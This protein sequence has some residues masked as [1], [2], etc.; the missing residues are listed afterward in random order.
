MID[1]TQVKDVK[2]LVE[3]R[4]ALNFFINKKIVAEIYAEEGNEKIDLE[5]DRRMARKLLENV[6]ARLRQ[7]N[8]QALKRDSKTHRQVPSIGLVAS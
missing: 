7:L 8:P 2:E 3:M 6:T 4:N 1:V 5:I